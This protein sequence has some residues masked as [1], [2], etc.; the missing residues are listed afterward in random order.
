MKLGVVSDTHIP[1][2]GNRLPEELLKA[3]E[4]V[5]K[6]LHAGDILNLETLRE[7]QKITET[8]AVRGNMDYPETTKA[9]PDKAIL[10]LEGYRLLLTHAE[11]PRRAPARRV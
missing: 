11:F 6:I 1:A 7:F 5:D 9:L 10:E 2:R 4:D 8:V 3:L